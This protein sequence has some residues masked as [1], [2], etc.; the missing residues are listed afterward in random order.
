MGSPSGDP[1]SCRHLY[2]SLVLISLPDMNKPVIK[3]RY[4]VLAC[5]VL[6][7]AVIMFAA[8]R[9]AKHYVVKHSYELL[10]RSVSIDKI[11]LN[12]FTGT[13]RIDG[14]KLFEQ[15]G[16]TIFV[17]FER[18][19]VNLDYIPLLRNEIFVKY[20]SLEAPYAQVLQNGERFNFS[21]LTEKTDSSTVENDTVASSPTKYIINNIG[22]SRGYLKY[23]DQVLDHT[24]AM[25]NLDLSIPGFTWNSDSTNLNVNFR[26][27]DGGGLYSKLEINQADSTYS[28]NLR[29]D[30]LNLDIIEPYIQSNMYI[31]AMHG[32]LSNDIRIKG[33][34]QSIMQMIVSG[35]NH[36]YGLQ[37][38]DTLNRTIFS[39]KELTIDVDTV[40]PASNRIDINSVSLSDPF[41][42]FE[43]V[44][45]TNNW[46]A[47][48]KP[49]PEA[50][51]DSLSRPAD[52]T[53]SN[54]SFSY[55]FPKLAITGGKITFS[56]KT[57]R[58]PFDYNIENLTIDCSESP[59]ERN[60]LS[61]RVSAGLNGTGNLNVNA[62]LNPASMEDFD[63]ALSVGQ[64]RMK[65][66]EPYF[67][68]YLGYP[69][70]S[71]IMNFKTDD[72]MMPGSLTSNNSLY[73]RKFSLAERTDKNCEYK[74]PVRLA[75]GVLSDKD[76]IIDLKAPVESKGDEVKVRNLGR[77]IFRII[78]NLFVK[79][80][81]SPFNALAGAF[82][83][84]PASLQEIRL[85]L[86][87]PQ[88]DE[89]N[90]K[91]V[92]IIAD[93][94]KTKPGLNAEFYYCID[95]NKA[96]DS[97]SYLLAIKDF[98]DYSKS[99]GIQVRNV[100]DSTLLKYL[101]EKPFS[102]DLKENPQLFVLCRKY[103]GETKLDN[104]LDS[105]RNL[106]TAFMTSYLGTDKALPADR[107]KV[108]SVSPDTIRPP[109]NYPAFKTYFNAGD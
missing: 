24:I 91:S 37:L 93:I 76:G 10:G 34:M 108:I 72:R 20:I 75:I 92:D 18:L 58:Y 4:K 8:P 39:F 96:A 102:T 1:F 86:T 31:S 25:N 36:I 104:M 16:K 13:L 5:I 23:T 81:V 103:I 68:H 85:G 106:Q 59:G 79:A 66:L 82:N 9:V 43:L 55:T 89:D 97:L 99:T 30:S 19:K 52:T 44:D 17:S 95:R 101:L 35:V 48:L 94:L 67:L 29:L 38:T 57:L 90:M 54:A 32:Y 63:L 46:M 73:F 45:T 56:D 70:T 41:I 60:K 2:L 62:T 26:F 27:V 51:S 14:L 42:L 3:M 22:I 11:R 74:I 69:V 61:L 100:A 88:P 107:F 109:L 71:G 64:F 65:D 12:Y 83:A 80:A 78:G 105:I 84:D 28:L 7:F 77:I 87:E 50:Q 53:G 47:L 21:D 98:T 49:T 33:N 15:D 6:F 40:M